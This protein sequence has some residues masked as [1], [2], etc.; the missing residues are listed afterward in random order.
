MQAL[1]SSTITDHV[2]VLIQLNGENDGLNTV[3]PLDQ[4]SNLSL[5]SQYSYSGYTEVLALNGVN[6]TGLHPAMSG[7][8]K[9][10]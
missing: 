8:K 7:M 6:G 4:Y 2:L 3:I 9:I 10:Y 1:T 5:A